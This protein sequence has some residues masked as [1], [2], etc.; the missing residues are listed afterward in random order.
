MKPTMQR[1]LPPM[2]DKRLD[3]LPESAK[4]A[5]KKVDGPLDAAKKRAGKAV[6]A[7]IGEEAVRVYGD[8]GLM[9]RVMSGPGIPDY[10][11]RIVERP[12][13]LRRYA[14]ALLSEVPNIRITTNVAWEEE[15]AV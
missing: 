15:K 7:A 5:V 10:M 4:T 6:R 14:V 2:E 1:T 13:A 3:R 12:D 11:A 8:E 9:S